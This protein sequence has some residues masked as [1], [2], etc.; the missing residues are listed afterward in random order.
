MKGKIK[1]ISQKL[2]KYLLTFNTLITV[3]SCSA[4]SINKSLKNI[5]ESEYGKSDTECT[6]IM[7]LEQPKILIHDKDCPIESLKTLS[8]NL[9]V[10]KNKLDTSS[11]AVIE[12]SSFEILKR[13]VDNLYDLLFT[14]TDE[15]VINHDYYQ[16]WTE[17]KKKDILEK[18]DLK[19]NENEAINTSYLQWGK[20]MKTP[21]IKENFYSIVE[22]FSQLNIIFSNVKQINDKPVLCA[23]K[24]FTIPIRD[25]YVDFSLK[26]W[27]NTI[28]YLNSVCHDSDGKEFL[29]CNSKKNTIFLILGKNKKYLLG[30]NPKYCEDSNGDI[31]TISDFIKVFK[32]NCIC[33]DVFKELYDIKIKKIG[34]ES[35]HIVFIDKKT[36]EENSLECDISIDVLKK[37]FDF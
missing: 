34:T 16:Y 19:I 33:R 37:K 27:D 23:I 18:L 26:N 36:K 29:I 31:G 24:K 9:D 30:I 6:S 32:S 3:F 11:K 20:D 15:I 21:I 17:G 12:S 13:N 14:T 8:E 7:L 25:Y 35:P 1:K 10:S 4:S 5:T 2:S 28:E 22:L